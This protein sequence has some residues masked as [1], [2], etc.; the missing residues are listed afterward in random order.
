LLGDQLEH[1][2]GL[3]DVRQVNLGLDLIGFAAGTRLGGRGLGFCSGAEMSADLLSFVFLDRTRMRL[4]LGN[5]DFSQY[6]KDGLALDLE[7]PGQIVDSNLTHPPFLG[8]AT[9]P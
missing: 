4:L 5:S 7:F 2:A 1:I 9:A 3:G 6:V 8:P